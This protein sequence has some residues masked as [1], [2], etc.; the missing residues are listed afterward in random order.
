[1][2][3]LS[4][5]EFFLGVPCILVEDKT[6]FLGLGYNSLWSDWSRVASRI[7][8][9]FIWGSIIRSFHLDEVASALS[10][11]SARVQGRFWPLGHWNL[12]LAVSWDAD[13]SCN[14]SRCWDHLSILLEVVLGVLLATY[15]TVWV[16]TLDSSWWCT[17]LPYFVVFLDNCIPSR[18]LLSW[19]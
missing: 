11:I 6:S 14:L 8:L 4:G 5:M 19:W 15:R 12:V 10:L 16:L 2:M 9:D 3:W 7:L 18:A 17:S 1:M 13:N